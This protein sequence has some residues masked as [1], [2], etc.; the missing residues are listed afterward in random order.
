MSVTQQQTFRQRMIFI[1]SYWQLDVYVTLG[2]TRV[3]FHS[4]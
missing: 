3:R 1:F 2:T 4:P